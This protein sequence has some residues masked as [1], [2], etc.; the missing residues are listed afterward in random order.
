[1]STRDRILERRAKFITT[2][3]VFAAGCSREQGVGATKVPDG[4]GKPKSS[5]APAQPSGPV[6]PP[7]GRPAL[8]ATV[9]EAGVTHRSE[10]VAR[11]E[12]TYE[13]TAKLAAAVPAVCPLGHAECKAR[14]EVFANEWARLR[15]DLR[16]FFGR[17]AAKTPDDKAVEAMLRAH[18]AWLQ[19]WL[20]AIEVAGRSAVEGDAGAEWEDLLRKAQDAHPQ[21][22]LKYYC[23]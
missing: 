2:A 10:A 16:G 7:P 18:H 1:M 17:C 20:G 6:K 3:L 4:E 9:S 19:Q 13:A 11:I 23:P 22:C 12:R 5:L 14:F 21:P 8:E 15:D